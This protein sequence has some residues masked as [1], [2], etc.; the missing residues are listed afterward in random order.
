[1]I[2]ILIFIMSLIASVA[3][4]TYKSLKTI[5][6]N[7]IDTSK[8]FKDGLNIIEGKSDNGK[9]YYLTYYKK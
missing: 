7:N 8:K 1:M 3:S 5:E 4:K 6:T 9:K 2:I